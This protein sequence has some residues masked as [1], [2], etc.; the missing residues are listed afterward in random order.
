MVHV[1]RQEALARLFG[2]AVEYAQRGKRT[3][4][5]NA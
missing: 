1:R 3:L 5:I 4:A 2:V